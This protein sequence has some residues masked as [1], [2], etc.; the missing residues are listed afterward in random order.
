MCWKTYKAN[1]TILIFRFILAPSFLFSPPN[2]SPH[3]HTH[4]PN[5]SFASTTF[6]TRASS[7]MWIQNLMCV[8]TFISISIILSVCKQKHFSIHFMVN[9]IRYTNERHKW[10]QNQFSLF[11]LLFAICHAL[12]YLLFLTC[13]RHKPNKIFELILF[14]II[15]GLIT[16]LDSVLAL[17]FEFEILFE[18]SLH[19]QFFWYD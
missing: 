11:R 7:T 8:T 10:S 19:R 4:T 3:T 1:K 15:H 2:T 9:C 5:I 6:Q 13:S 12:L 18:N 16:W 14:T 17:L